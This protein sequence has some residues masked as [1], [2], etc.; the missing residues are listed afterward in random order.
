MD[1]ERSLNRGRMI[2]KTAFPNDRLLTLLVTHLEYGID[3]RRSRFSD[4]TQ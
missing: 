2:L 3:Q 1:A 4:Q